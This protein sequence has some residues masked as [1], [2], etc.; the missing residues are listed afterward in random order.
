MLYASS[1]NECLSLDVHE[2]IA[3]STKHI[4][5]ALHIRKLSQHAI[6]S[7]LF[8]NKDSTVVATNSDGDIY[9]ISMI[10]LDTKINAHRY[11]CVRLDLVMSHIRYD[12]Y[13]MT[14]NS[15]VIVISTLSY[16]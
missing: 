10:S 4:T 1:T 5:F 2:D 16:V 11:A 6:T 3:T 15:Y 12:S 9:V 13:V 7:V 8:M 14:H